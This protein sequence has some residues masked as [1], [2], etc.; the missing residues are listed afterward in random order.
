MNNHV[1]EINKVLYHLLFYFFI[2]GPN[3]LNIFKSLNVN[4]VLIFIMQKTHEIHNFNQ[5]SVCTSVTNIRCFHMVVQ[6][7]PPS[8]S[9]ISSSLCTEPLNPANSNTSSTSPKPLETNILLSV[10]MNLNVYTFYVCHLSNK[11]LMSKICQ[12]DRK[13]KNKKT[14]NPV[15]SS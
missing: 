2:H 1:L 5:F 15:K 11:G 3:I 7:L 14:T 13:L 6:P 4:F 12:Q 8:L 10:Y 9:K